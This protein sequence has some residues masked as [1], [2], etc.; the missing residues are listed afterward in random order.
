MELLEFWLFC[1]KIFLKWTQLE[2]SHM[3]LWAIYSFYDQKHYT[4]FNT[5]MWMLYPSLYHSVYPLSGSKFVCLFD[6]II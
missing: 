5:R 2:I 3:A 6:L 4:I 1:A